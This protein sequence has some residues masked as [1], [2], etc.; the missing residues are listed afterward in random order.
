MWSDKWCWGWSLCWTSLVTV[1]HIWRDAAWQMIIV[2][3]IMIWVEALYSDHW[4]MSLLLWILKQIFK[5]MLAIYVL[6]L[7]ELF[8]WLITSFVA[9]V[10]CISFFCLDLKVVS[11]SYDFTF[12]K[13]SNKLSESKELTEKLIFFYFEI[14]CQVVFLNYSLKCDIWWQMDN[15]SGGNKTCINFQNWHW[16]HVRVGGGRG[17][18]S[19]ITQ[20]WFSKIFG[21]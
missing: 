12:V 5:I 9:D 16:W 6:L 15:G 2:T 3:G 8:I 18:G 21:F 17:G 7:K 19:R 20:Q 11:L 14:V 10:S 1:W 13:H 4:L